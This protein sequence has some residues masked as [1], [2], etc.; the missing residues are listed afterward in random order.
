MQVIVTISRITEACKVV[1]LAFACL[2]ANFSAQASETAPAQ[3]SS[4]AQALLALLADKQRYRA[5]F[6]HELRD[7]DGTL[8]DASSGWLAW[9]RPH[10]FRWETEQPLAQTLLVKGDL[11]YQYDSDLEQMLV[12]PLS[13]DVAVLPRL[14]LG[15]DAAAIADDYRV[16]AVRVVAAGAGGKTPDA[17]TDTKASAPAQIFRL[18]P[19]AE[20]GLFSEL[21]LEFR[22]GELSAINISDDLQ[23]NSRFEFQAIDSDIDA[24]LFEVSPPPGTEIVHQ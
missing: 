21:L 17:D 9:L 19:R 8:L 24:A 15:G 12:Q 11:F 14:L 13:D 18:Q 5:S 7:S 23:Q 10:S 6:S 4:D 20:G 1:V 3:D 16:S 22:G 2:V